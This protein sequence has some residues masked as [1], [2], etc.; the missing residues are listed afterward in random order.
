MSSYSHNTQTTKLTTIDAI[1]STL[2]IH[3]HQRVNTK[4]TRQHLPMARRRVSKRSAN[5]LQHRRQT[6]PRPIC[7]YDLRTSHCSTARRELSR[8]DELRWKYLKRFYYQIRAIDAVSGDVSFDYVDVT[9][10]A[11][12]AHSTP[13]LNAHHM[14]R[15]V[16]MQNTVSSSGYHSS[17]STSSTNSPVERQRQKVIVCTFMH[18]T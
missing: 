2:P 8:L 3:P 12:D 11:D 17:R 14:R 13:Q 16:N 10:D 7:Q 18:S 15:A 1:V 5:T 4:T 6:S 9:P